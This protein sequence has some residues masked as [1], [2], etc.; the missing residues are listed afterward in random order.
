M[1]PGFL[2]RKQK[3]L[4]G[5]KLQMT[6]LKFIADMNISPLTVAE[7]KKG[8]VVSVDETSIRYRDLPIKLE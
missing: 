8:V 2:L 3:L 1:P 4:S 7:L 5:S 6:E